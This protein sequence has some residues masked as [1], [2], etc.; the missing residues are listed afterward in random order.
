MISGI[1]GDELTGGVVDPAAELADYI[2]KGKARGRRQTHDILVLGEPR[3]FFELSG[4]TVQYLA[5]HMGYART[6]RALRDIPWLTDSVREACSTSIRTL[7][8]PLYRPF[9]G[10]PSSVGICSDWWYT[11]RNQPH[12]RPSEIYRFE[13]RYPY[14]DRDLVDFLL[15]VPLRQLAAPG[16]RR[17]MMRR[18]LKGIVPMEDTAASTQSVLAPEPALADQR[19]K[20]ANPA[21]Y[22]SLRSRRVGTY[23]MRR[24]STEHSTIR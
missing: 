3:N 12:L 23:S 6:D 15:R 22:S 20:W 4:R 19:H 13:Y 9:A 8:I 21:P 7:P 17:F 11:L 1:G 24:L 2:V 16:R 14:L 10:R 5:Q 18:T